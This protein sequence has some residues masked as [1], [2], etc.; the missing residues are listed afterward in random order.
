MIKIQSREIIHYLTLHRHLSVAFCPAHDIFIFLFSSI[1]KLREA[2]VLNYLTTLFLEPKRL[3]ADLLQKEL[4]IIELHHVEYIFFLLIFLVA[5]SILLLFF[6]IS[7][8]RILSGTRE[9]HKRRHD[10]YGILKSVNTDRL[11]TKN[12]YFLP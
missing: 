12:F 7:L 1:M 9:R 6:E 2:G 11:K 4:E 5:F 3:E 8:H 10:K